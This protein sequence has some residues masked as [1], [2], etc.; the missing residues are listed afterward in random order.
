MVATKLQRF[1]GMIPALD[2]QLLPEN[3]AAYSQ[4][5]WVYS[6][7][8]AGMHVPTP[9][10]T[11]ASAATTKVFRFPNN[12][13]DNILDST[14]IEFENP[15]TDIIRAPVIGDTFERYYWASTSAAPQ[16]N[17]A[18]RMKAGSPA[19]LLGIPSPAAPT[20]SSTGGASELTVSRA[21]V[22]TYVTAYGE[23][24]PPSPPASLTGKTDDTWTITL[25]TAST[26]DTTNRNLTHRR[27][28]RTITSSNGVAT[29]FLVVELPIATTSYD[30]TLSDTAVSGNSQLQSTSWTPP[31][32][33]LEGFSAM[34]NGMIAA[35]RENELWFCEPYR[36]HAWPASYVLAV[37]F[38]IVG[39]G[40]IGQTLVECT[41]GFP[42]AATG[43]NPASV[44]LSKLSVYE[45][46]LSRGSIV[47][48]PEGVYYAS[49]NGLV[50]VGGG[51]VRNITRELITKDKWQDLVSAATLRAV[52]LGTAYYA[53]GAARVGSFE[54]SAFE[55]TVFAQSDFSGA[56]RGLLVDPQNER[57]GFNA[58][59][60]PIATTN[61][62][63]AVWSGEVF[64]IREGEVYWLNIADQTPT[65]EVFR[66]RSKIFQLGG[67]KNLAAMRVYFSVPATSPELNPVRD[68]N[69]TQEVTADKYGVVRVFA[70][71]RLV[72]TFELRSSGELIR[73]PSGFKAEFWQFEIAAR[74][75]ITSVQISDTVEALKSV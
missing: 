63:S 69:L 41:E 14:W 65:H 74:V 51:T 46:C 13:N 53:F 55:P 49:Q 64:I 12:F 57:I 26:L 70:D 59:Y 24:G 30:D 43:I 42:S 60:S 40:V 3:A 19:Y 33:D 25:G 17:T 34:P 45:P 1:G 22:Y 35:W 61:V 5:A 20:V 50:L 29:Y 68:T 62:V 10:Y 21:Y 71:E 15:D 2:E 27:V 6:G 8:L 44:S 23:E 32:S 72:Q 58:L 75:E 56:Y 67:K 38:P 31:P 7:R 9:V 48:A 11:C 52:R 37:E 66:W 18:A 4:N 28:Y 36:P 47:S 54:S 73:M 16:Y 39:L